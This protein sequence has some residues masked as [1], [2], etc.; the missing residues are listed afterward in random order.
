MILAAI[1]ILIF[2][3][4]CVRGTIE[5]KN[6]YMVKAYCE[7]L[8]NGILEFFF[9]GESFEYVLEKGDKIP[10]ENIVRI[11]MDNTGTRGF[12]KDD[13]ILKYY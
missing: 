9:K 3:A 10:T 11:V 8:R 7:Y 1:L 5:N 2:G 12:L 4:T 6:Q 13:S